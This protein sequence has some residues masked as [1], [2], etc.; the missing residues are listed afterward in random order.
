LAG[1][2][3]DALLAGRG[4]NGR[5]ARGRRAELLRRRRRLRLRG[6][7]VLLALLRGEG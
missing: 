1:G 4:K 7:N 3:K 5:V 6:L 2:G